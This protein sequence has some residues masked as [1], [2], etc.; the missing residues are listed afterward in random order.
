MNDAISKPPAVQVALPPS[1]RLR[2]YLRALGEMHTLKQASLIAFIIFIALTA[3]ACSSDSFG[4]E[5][6]SPKRTAIQLEQADQSGHA[7]Q[8]NPLNQSYD[9]KYWRNFRSFAPLQRPPV[10]NVRNVKHKHWP[11]NPIDAFILVRLEASNLTPAPRADARTLVRRATF[12]A[13]GLPPTTKQIEFVTSKTASPATETVPA[14]WPVFIE[15]LMKSPHLGERYGQR[16]LDLVRFDEQRIRLKH[17]PTF[18]GELHYRDYVIRA[19]NQDKPYDRFVQE[20]LAGDLMNVPDSKGSNEEKGRADRQYLDQITAAAFLSL[21][22]WFD[23]CTDPNQLRMD[24]TDELIDTTGKVFMGLSLGCAR[25]H[26]HPF[27]PI[28]TE[29]YYAMA[30]VFHNTKI[31]GTFNEQWRDGRDRMTRELAPFE[32][33]TE[34]TL[35]QQYI[36]AAYAH[37]RRHVGKVAGR[38]EETAI[39]KSYTTI[40]KEM[41]NNSNVPLPQV[42]TI[43]AERFAGTD[44]LKIIKDK[45]LKPIEYIATQT[46]LAQWVRY[47]YRLH[48][49]GRYEIQLLSRS[50]NPTPI[51]IQA[52]RN[53]SKIVLESKNGVLKDLMRTWFGWQSVG[54]YVLSAGP[55]SLRLSAVINETSKTALFPDI[56]KIRFIYRSNAWKKQVKNLSDKHKLSADLLEKVAFNVNDDLPLFGDLNP[57]L[58]KNEQAD[59][60]T[61]RNMILKAKSQIKQYP[62]IL[63]VSDEKEIAD[64]PVHIRGSVYRTHKTKQ[65]RGPIQLFDHV[66]PRQGI[67]A[68]QSG[69]LQ[70]ARW[71]TH[72]H[73]PLT[74]R[75]MVNRIWQ[76]HFGRGLVASPND[77]GSQG[78]ASTHPKLLDWLAVEFIESGWSMKHIHKLIMTS[79]TYRMKSQPFA[80]AAC[81]KANQVDPNNRLYWHFDRKR[82][83]A[84]AIYDA[85]ASSIGKI[86]YQ[87]DKPIDLS[88]SANRMMYVLTSNRS[89]LGMGVHIRRMFGVF[90]Y[91][92]DG[93]P[94]AVRDQSTTSRQALWWLNNPL[95]KY[96]AAQFA[97]R[98][99]E[100]EDVSDAQRLDLAWR[101]ALGRPPAQV[102]TDSML[103][104]LQELT[105]KNN[106]TSA[107]AW[108]RVCLAIYSSNDFRYVE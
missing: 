13:W 22:D 98:L 87:L 40:A 24:I 35:Q 75:V 59:L 29:D 96:F 9:W 1:M 70:L 78:S 34:F 37:L 15:Q 89:P 44:N 108:T 91:Q 62:L 45:R 33:W 58:N 56:D 39:G 17:Q 26:D 85:M 3:L 54:T 23:E 36:H 73:N 102:E 57:F 38:F 74:A 92:P 106:L 6:S 46:P 49:T 69:R 67:D 83:E 100:D 90:D 21:G 55:N 66:V 19:F 77:F 81:A 11:T 76:W 50:N 82:L 52:G 99:L 86:K 53:P 48:K 60:I 104:Y 71:L 27:D 7:E 30:G 10:P 14:S 84:E 65:P 93:R 32:P 28:T 5:Q 16:W 4:D 61:I 94:L 88:K 63:S 95:P 107:A 64:L 12:D 41:L 47:S 101:M 97:Q 8:A 79:S 31:I 72:K 42:V 80:N 43:E 103:V 51:S 20:Q 25:C 105:A 18:K 68:N 2:M